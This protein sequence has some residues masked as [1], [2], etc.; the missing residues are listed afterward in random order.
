MQKAVYPGSF[1]PITM[2]HLNI[3]LRSSK[4]FDSLIVAVLRNP[5][6]TPI[7]TIEE[8]VD[9]IRRSIEG[10]PN[11]EVESFS[12]LL[13]KYLEQ[14]KASIIIKGL[15]AISDFDFEFQMA[16]MNRKLDSNIETVF[17]MT[18]D[19][20][21]FLSS[22]KVKEIYFLG[23]NARGLVPDYVEHCLKE[24]FMDKSM[25]PGGQDVEKD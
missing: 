13:V 22:S 19:K 6:K 4:I 10:I 7:F 8:R 11:I 24:K 25:L 21:A 5:Q 9:M 20:Y 16:L 3:I 18:E 15:R 1:D 2:G 17:L 14:R 12:G 23:G